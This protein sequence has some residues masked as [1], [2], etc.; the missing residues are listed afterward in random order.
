MAENHVQLLH[1][2]LSAQVAQ[3]SEVIDDKW[4]SF[5]G[6]ELEGRPP[7]ALCPRC[8]EQ[9]KRATRTPRPT[10]LC[11]QCYRADLDRQHAFSAAATLDTASQ[12]RFEY[13]QPFEPVDKPRLE[14]LKAERM[15]SRRSLTAGTGRFEDK[16]RRAQLAARRTLQR[17]AVGLAAPRLPVE[18]GQTA[19]AAV[20][21]AELQ[22]PESWLPFV[23][24]Y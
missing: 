15:A 19:S 4:V 7:K 20:H 21:A 1:A 24:R 2:A 16:R 11:F 3:V 6:G 18:V 8:R 10:T 5:P 12:Q 23:M 13:G 9:L 22:L 14:M 17:L